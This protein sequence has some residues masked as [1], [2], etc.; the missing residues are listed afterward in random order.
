MSIEITQEASKELRKF[1]EKK[2]DI[3]KYLRIYVAGFGWGGPSFG[4][5]LDEQ[6]DEDEVIK[7]DDFTFLLDADMVNNFSDFTIDYSN[8]WLR[9]GFQVNAGRGGPSC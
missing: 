3:N 9:K 5:A 4:I 7:V 8:S 6:K 2:H 1:L